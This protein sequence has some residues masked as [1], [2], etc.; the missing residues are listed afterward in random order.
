MNAGKADLFRKWFLF[1]L[2]RSGEKALHMNLKTVLAPQ[3]IIL[4]VLVNLV[5]LP[6][7]FHP[8]QAT[9][10]LMPAEDNLTKAAA[11]DGVITFYDH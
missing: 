10:T 3:V 1:C 8:K 6:D 2:T 5:Y 11:I 4:V 9:L 7:L